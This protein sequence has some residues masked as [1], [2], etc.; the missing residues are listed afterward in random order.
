MADAERAFTPI[1]PYEAVLADLRTKRDEI[2]HVI[3]T[4]EGFKSGRPTKAPL[5][6]TAPSAEA[7]EAAFG[8]FVG[9]NIVDA[10]SLLLARRG[11]P[12][13]VV[14]IHADL[15]SGGLVMNSAEPV[16][17]IGSVLAR[18]FHAVGD[19]VRVGRG[20]WGLAEWFPG[21]EFKRNIPPEAHEI[22]D[23]EAGALHNAGGIDDGIAPAGEIQHSAPPIPNIRTRTR[24]FPS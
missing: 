12:M 2:D 19:I 3:R 14:D 1:D 23:A 6:V 18:R 8:P 11:Q 9:M 22:I 15:K 16:N 24:L 17:V 21:R 5:S 13:Q 20:T 10:T 4:L 7:P